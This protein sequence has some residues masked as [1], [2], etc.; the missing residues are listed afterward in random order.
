MAKLEDGMIKLK[1]P[2]PWPNYKDL[3]SEE[4]WDKYFKDNQY[5]YD[6]PLKLALINSFKSNENY[7]IIKLLERVCEELREI[8]STL[9]KIYHCQ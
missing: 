5:Y 1:G 6:D 9:E 2:K 8:D 7:Q 4:D 3:V